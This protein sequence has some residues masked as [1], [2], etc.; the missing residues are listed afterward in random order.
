MTKRLFAMLLCAAMLLS[1]V[2]SFGIAAADAAET[3]AEEAAAPVE[4]VLLDYNCDAVK[5]DG[6]SLR[7]NKYPSYY[8]VDSETGKEEGVAAGTIL[9]GSDG[10]T[11]GDTSLVIP[12]AD[13]K[14]KTF[15]LKM[16]LKIEDLITPTA[17]ADKRGFYVDFHVPG[18][19]NI[20]FYVN[21]LTDPDDDGRNATV[22]L[23]YAWNESCVYNSRIAI[24]T[25]GE[26]HT[27]EILFNGE[28]EIRM[29]IDNELKAVFEEISLNAQID[30][31]YLRIGSTTLD[32]A[33]GTTNKIAIDNISVTEG[34]NFGTTKVL[35]ALPTRDSSAK[36]LTVK[37]TLNEVPNNCEITV[38]IIFQDDRT[39]T[40]KTTYKP[41]AEESS[42]TI[43][44]IPFNG[45]CEGVISVTG[46]MDY[47]FDLYLYADYEVVESGA[48]I[49]DD[50]PNKAYV[51]T[52]MGS[53]ELPKDSKWS[54]GYTTDEFGTKGTILSCQSSDPQ[55]FDVPVELDG[56]FAIYIGYMQGT[57]RF[58]VNGRE[59]FVTY[60]NEN[61]TTIF[62]HFGAA[63]AFEGTKA[64]V[65]NVPGT[66]LSVAYVKI[67]PITEEQY[68]L[69]QKEDDSHNLMY[70]VDGFSIFC[71]AGVNTV[72]ELTYRA[73]D[74]YAPMEATLNWATFST[75]ILNYNSETW[76]K[77]V[78]ARLKELNIPE[79]KWPENFLDHVNNK[80]EH[81]DFT[82]EMRDLD[83]NA[84]ANM[85]AIGEVGF[86][87]HI[88]AD[89]AN[90]KGYA[91]IFVSQRM[92]HFSNGGYQSGTLY[93]LYP[94]F[95]RGGS[96]QFSFYY[97][98]YRNYMHDLLIEN[99]KG[100]NIAGITMDFGRYPFIF[101]SELNDV[102]KRT[103]IMN[104]FVKSVREDLPE[105]KKLFARVLHPT[106]DKALSW[107][108]D[109][110][111]WCEQGWID[112]LMIS[113][114]GHESF[115]NFDEYM[116]Y[117]NEHDEVEFYLGINAS[118]SGHDLTKEEED[119]LKAGGT[120]EQGER[121]KFEDFM[122]RGYEAYMAGA[123]GIFLFNGVDETRVGGIDPAYAYLN[124]KT[125][126]MQWYEFEYP[127][128]H[129]SYSL[130]SLEE[131]DK[132][133]VDF[134]CTSIEAAGISAGANEGNYFADSTTSKEVEE[135]AVL[136]AGTDPTKDYVTMKFPL[137][138]PSPSF[139]LDMN[140][141]IED[142]MTPSSAPSWR[143]FIVEIN[144]PNAPLI[145]F[146]L[147]A[148]D[149][150]GNA[151]I[152]IS[153][154]KRAATDVVKTIQLPKDGKY[155]KWTV[156][157]DGASEANFYL[158]GK[159]IA[160]VPNI[161]AEPGNTKSAYLEFKNVM[162]NHK[163]G[164][165]RVFFDHITL[166]SGVMETPVIKKEDKTAEKTEEK[167]DTATALEGGKEAKAT[168][169]ARAEVLPLPV[170]D[171][172]W[173]KATTLEKSEKAAN[174]KSY[175]KEATVSYK[176]NK[177][178]KTLQLLVT[179]NL[180]S[181]LGKLAVTD[182]DGKE[183]K[184]TSD[185]KWGTAK[186]GGTLWSFSYA[187]NGNASATKS[188]LLTVENVTE[189]PKELVL[190]ASNCGT[191]TTFTAKI[192]IEF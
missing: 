11:R 98:T 148:M 192:N 175:G 161:V 41:D 138:L 9:M 176:Y 125:K 8:I 15:S 34:I 17:N 96:W 38:K 104:E 80:G 89:H 20:Q 181:W 109:Y 102:E 133:E 134:N 121:V 107:G 141:K 55:S 189:M 173:A 110:Q 3:T 94:E 31:G 82:D 99:A 62:E 51:F 174:Y 28:S 40:V 61:G 22:Y 184:V 129:F 93:F 105:D 92:S 103:E 97:D 47:S 71:S 151:K 46:G 127:A 23:K 6:I 37:T 122:L 58:A 112:R 108:L 149:D 42:V 101:G 145:Y 27:W 177:D 79:E 33:E 139:R 52:N 115:F 155:H 111:Y 162:G 159:L 74:K 24:P 43:E 60:K 164:E 163:E 169:E 170:S 135:G 25:D 168:V 182:A 123:D 45:M 160:N 136:M 65:S 144:N 157:F 30:T 14:E 56:N 57:K 166:T 12:L 88:L 147:N 70:D 7:G 59:N 85:L 191:S 152:Y 158:D 18:S 64:T 178:A 53:I 143:G 117:F 179:Y 29:Y 126:M 81:L 185:R 66:P 190:F 154:K 113:E 114:Q 13:M 39:Q 150:A 124:N 120:I 118:I 48:K 83:K 188:L 187:D 75:S 106:K 68:E 86:P 167:K 16:D 165:N 132:V 10:T 84:Y 1:F 91:E 4:K 95:I 72:K 142:L 116:D 186:A 50:T 78:H 90:E 128:Y 137:T 146:V 140:L 77:Y 87:H 49:T 21:D 73:L 76:W 2:P 156:E 5:A 172:D 26:F 32:A 130:A 153:Q 100:E 54:V 171:A 63:G 131:K 44:D 183:L 67:V 36:A 69:Y 119:I 35:S 19:R 180:N